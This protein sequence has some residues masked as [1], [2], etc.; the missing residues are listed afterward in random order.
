MNI[1]IKIK[2]IKD[3]SKFKKYNTAFRGYIYR[4]W[5]LRDREIALH[6]SP[7]KDGIIVCLCTPYTGDW[8]WTLS[9]WKV[10]TEEKAVE[11]INKYC[12]KQNRHLRKRKKWKKSCRI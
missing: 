11:V 10:N 3:L 1:K 2:P 12:I 9:E 8:G 7:N 5:R 6:E 4:G